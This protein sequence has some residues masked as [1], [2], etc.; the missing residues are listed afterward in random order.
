MKT[1]KCSHV[2]GL[3]IITLLFPVLCFS[4]ELIEIQV[5]PNVLNLNNNGTVV[6]IHTD[7]AFLYVLGSTVTLNGI[8]IQSWKADDCGDFVAK[9]NM[10]EVKNLELKIDEYNTMTLTGSK[11]DNSTFIGSTEIM[12]KNIIPSKK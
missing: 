5:S 7:I 8:E 4:Q 11:I 3:M 12:V 9:F 1:K 10:D 6:T 2:F